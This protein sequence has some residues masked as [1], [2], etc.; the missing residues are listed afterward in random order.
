[1]EDILN[2]I[3]EAYLKATGKNPTDGSIRMGEE[4]D[5]HCYKAKERLQT[6]PTGLLSIL[7]MKQ[8]F[9][10]FIRRFKA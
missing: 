6:D 9:K 2:E 1:M 3:F 10:A 4:S 8:A 7:T 5:W